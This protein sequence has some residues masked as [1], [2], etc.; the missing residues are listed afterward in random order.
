MKKYDH[1]KDFNRIEQDNTMLLQLIADE[2]AARSKE[3]R[4]EGIHGGHVGTIGYMREELMQALA[5]MMYDE[6]STEE[7]VSNKIEKM[8]TKA[9][10]AGNNKG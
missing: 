6:D 7:Q 2:L 5:S 3:Y 9:K 1:E 8:I 4:A 10:R